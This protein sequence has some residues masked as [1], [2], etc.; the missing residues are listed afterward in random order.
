LSTLVERSFGGFVRRQSYKWYLRVPDPIA[1][2]RHIQPVLERRLEGSGANR[3]TG[4]FRIGFYDL[5]GIVLKFE[6]GRIVEIA[7]MRGKDGYDVSFPWHL[8]WNVV[9]GDQ[10]VEEIQAILPEVHA[11]GGK[12]A[13]LINALFPKK[14]SWLE[15]L[16]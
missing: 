4:E 2:L 8:F 14:K 10:S 13:V 3:Y 12:G 5:T 11:R 9:F 6:D 7:P 1:F 16:A 15:G